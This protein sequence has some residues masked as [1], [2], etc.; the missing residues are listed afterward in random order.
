MDGLNT[1]ENRL[2]DDVNDDD[3]DDDNDDNDDDDRYLTDLYYN[4][5]SPVGLSSADRIWKYIKSSTDRNISKKYIKE[6]LSKQ[7]AY[8]LHRPSRKKFSRPRVISFYRNYQWDSDTANMV[9]FEKMNNGYKYFVVFIDIF[10]RYL[11]TKPLKT[12]QG[13]EMVQ[14]MK[15]TFS[16]SKSQPINIRTDKGSEYKNRYVKTYLKDIDVN[17][18]FTSFETKANYA[19]RV[20]K[21]IK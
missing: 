16:E 11:Y 5:E 10:T 18:I 4:L 3:N 2:N 14:A 20:I 8:T 12:L 17:H 1:G 13:E 6:W 21:T 9:K 15:S 7:D 19:E